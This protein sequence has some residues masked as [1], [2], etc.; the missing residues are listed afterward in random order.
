MA[1]FLLHEAQLLAK[2]LRFNIDSL[3]NE[4]ANTKTFTIK[5]FPTLSTPQATVA[6]YISELH[7]D[8]KQ[9]HS[10]GLQQMYYAAKDLP[11]FCFFSSPMLTSF[12]L[13]FWYITIFD[14]NS[15]LNKFDTNWVASEVLN[16]ANA[17]FKLY[18]QCDSTEIWNFETINST[19]HQIHYCQEAGL[20]SKKDTKHLLTALTDFV[21]QLQANCEAGRKNDMGQLTM[22]LNEILLLDNSVIFDTKVIKIYYLP[23]QTLNF[24]SNTDK[25]FTDNNLK[26]FNKQIAK[27]TIISSASQRDRNRLISHYLD[28][29]ENYS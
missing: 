7:T 12:K 23:F 26:W 5:N 1:A 22:Y 25:D 17:V 19:L 20:I 13:Y 10:M 4:L 28:E 2:T 18:C 6:A 27:S 8:L 14:S 24:L 3:D 15:S 11:L 21:N 29:I 16:E 9:V